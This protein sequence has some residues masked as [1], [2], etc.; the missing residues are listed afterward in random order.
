M[1]PGLKSNSIIHCVKSQTG[2][3]LTN[4]AEINNRLSLSLYGESYSSK[5]NSLHTVVDDFF[6]SIQMPTLKE[7]AET[8][9]EADFTLEEIVTSI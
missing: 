1:F 6:G 2:T 5:N 4:P 3:L 8:D 7:T 9:V